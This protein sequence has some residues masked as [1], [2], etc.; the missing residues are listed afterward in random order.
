MDRD[1]YADVKSFNETAFCD[2]KNVDG[3]RQYRDVGTGMRHAMQD[4]EMWE[5]A[6]QAAE[7]QAEEENRN[8]LKDPLV[9][10]QQ[11]AF[12][13]PPAGAYK[14]PIGARVMK[15]RDGRDIPN[16]PRDLVFLKETG[17]RHPD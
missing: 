14:K 3:P 15:T 4:Q 10:T 17:I 6:T 5:A 8:V 16:D 2:P 11:E 13:G 12:Q 9:S 7:A 1:E